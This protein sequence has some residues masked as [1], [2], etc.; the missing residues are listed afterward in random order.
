[1]QAAP[2]AGVAL[3]Q[4]VLSALVMLAAEFFGAGGVVSAFG[5]V[6]PLCYLGVVEELHLTPYLAHELLSRENQRSGKRKNV[7][8]WRG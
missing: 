2:F 3:N 6:A 7:P 1:M 4:S 5:G 8:P